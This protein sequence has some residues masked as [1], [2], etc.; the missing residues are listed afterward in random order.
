MDRILLRLWQREMIDPW[1][2]STISR[3]WNKQPV[4]D[5]SLFCTKRGQ[6]KR[7]FRAKGDMHQR[8]NQETEKV[9]KEL[10]VNLLE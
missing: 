5:N 1:I 4:S 8:L 6:N 10:Y 3:M 2:P 9:E 7:D